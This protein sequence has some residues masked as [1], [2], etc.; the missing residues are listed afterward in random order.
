MRTR[1]ALALFLASFAAA[2]Q[3]A[4]APDS[5]Q[6]D[7]IVR[8][9]PSP[10]N[11][12]HHRFAAH[13]ATHKASLS[14]IGAH[15]YT[16]NSRDL[17]LLSADPD[18]EYI[19]PDHK[20]QATAT[21]LAPDYGWM[22]ALGV[23][24]IT[25]TLPWD[26]T[27]IGIAVIDSGVN[28][29]ADL[30][31]S[32]GRSRIVYSQSFVPKDT[33]TADAYGH[34]TMVAGLIAGNGAQSKTSTA[35][36]VIRGIAPNANIVNLRVL[37]QNG[38]ATDSTVI[39]AIQQAIALKSKYNIRVMNLSLGR[40]VYQSYTQDP[41]C[42][43]VE[44]AWNAGIVVVVA[45][46][47]DG[48][49]NSQGT[50]GYATINVPGND[51]YV[52]AVGAMNTVGTLSRL[53]DKI[54]SYSS[55]GPTLIDH[56]VKPDLVAPGNRVS[57]LEASNSSLVKTYSN[58]RVPWSMYD[59]SKTA[60]PSP[61]YFYLSGTS[62]ATPDVSGAAALLLQQNP[63]LTPDQVKARLMKTAWKLPAVTTISVDPVTGVQYVSENDIF[64]VGAGYLNVQAALNSTDIATA[65]AISPAA[66]FND[67]TNTVTLVSGS[68]A[69][70]GT[71]AVWGTAAVWGTNV[72][73]GN[74]AVWGTNVLWGSG[75][76]WRTG[77]VWGTS[78]VWGTNAV[79]GTT[80]GIESTATSVA[81]AGE[82]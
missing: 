66:S 3:S 81:I 16:V 20:L 25:A 58:N 35:S 71:T 5:D 33:S 80:S 6:V 52:I 30:Q 76:V 1:T 75:A 38:S 68:N 7:V 9:K 82:N 45:A 61:A 34:G 62:L 21:T 14:V 50:Q 79:W 53:D 39:A 41:L 23:S 24:S 56:V 31:D 19:G 15:V 11:V 8:F 26:G 65:P 59:T 64:T 77:A 32:K 78:A 57:S 28:S 43:A 29:S 73:W 40:P 55:K 10:D 67:A 17:N 69:V 2:A 72:L 46:G 18:V 37:D 60:S 63:S 12:G 51:P 36:Y 13:G 42:Q 47:N 54:T 48:R 44:Q 70:W 27:G 74:G 22:T 4:V 49:D